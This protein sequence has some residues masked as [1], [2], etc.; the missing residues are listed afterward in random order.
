MAPSYTAVLRAP[1]AARTFG[2]ALLGRLSYG[3]VFL[4]LTFALTASTGS[5][6]TAG[7]LMA[8]LGLTIS[9]LSPLRARLIDRYGPRAALPPMSGAYALALLGLAAATWRPGAPAA[10]LVALI[11][12][13]GATAPPLGPVMRALWNDLAA[14]EALRRR[15]YSLDAVAEELLFITGPLL[16][17]L[18]AAAASPSLGV[19]ASAVLVA[20]GT[21]GLVTSPAVRPRPHGHR[22]PRAGRALR[23]APVTAA[24]A[25][26]AALGCME[27]LA[28]ASAR[29][30]H[31]ATGGAWVMAAMSA[32]SALGG[33]GY[34]AVAWRP[35]PR[36]RLAV[37]AGALG[38][39][40]AAAGLAPTVALLA[41]AMFAA[42]AFV[43]PSLTTSY[44]LADAEAA[45]RDRVRA[46][47]WVNT[48]VNLGSSAGTGAIGACLDALPLP[49]C[50]AVAAAPAVLAAPVLLAPRILRKRQ[51]S[52]PK[53]V[54]GTSMAA[55][56]TTAHPKDA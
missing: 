23:F 35:S 50:F 53:T 12:A 46:S 51:K 2:A 7:A 15:A 16:A 42:G 41:A 54:P 14:G 24:A 30:H 40:V 13:A 39:A 17:G 32:G 28:V 18:A 43:G 3:T 38:A 48:A 55:E 52:S 1:H 9:V 5:Y 45:P 27:L 37:L 31:H 34:G 36:V 25:T 56:T 10:L 26:G 6:T 33:L 11:A 22:P 44:L 29:H 20:A 49:A 47:A 21:L 4:S 8:S 19:A